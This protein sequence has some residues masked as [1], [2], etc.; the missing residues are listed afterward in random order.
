MTPP[1]AIAVAVPG[2]EG[3]GLGLKIAGARRIRRPQGKPVD[4]RA[5]ERRRIDR[6]DHVMRQHAPERGGKRDAFRRER[7]QIDRAC[8]ARARFVGGHDLEKLLLP[9]GR[10]HARQQILLRS[11]LR[12]AHGHGHT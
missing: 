9:R 10:A 7:R 5:I 11:R 6:G 2:V 3:E 1:V 8:K 4:I 12:L